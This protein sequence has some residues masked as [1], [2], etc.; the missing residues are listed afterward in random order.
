MCLE[1]LTMAHMVKRVAS[2]TLPA[3]GIR[4]STVLLVIDLFML[5]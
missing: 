4:V 3:K 5:V 2:A 1:G